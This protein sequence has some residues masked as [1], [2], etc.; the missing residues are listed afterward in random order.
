MRNS[1]AQLEAEVEQLHNEYKLLAFAKADDTQ[2]REDLAKVRKEK[3]RE[4]LR[5][6]D[7]LENA[8]L[9]ILLQ[10]TD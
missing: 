4:K 5:E 2:T 7:A 3:M 9:D 8:I 1:V 6:I 10:R